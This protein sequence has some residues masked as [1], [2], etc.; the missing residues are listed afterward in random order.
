[1][2]PTGT[3]AAPVR[4][5]WIC[6]PLQI[7][8]RL[9]LRPPPLR[10]RTSTSAQSP[11][12]APSFLMSRSSHV[13]QRP[14]PPLAATVAPFPAVAAQPMT[15]LHLLQILLRRLGISQIWPCEILA[16]P[17]DAGSGD[18]RRCHHLLGGAAMADICAPLRASGETLGPGFWIGR[19]CLVCSRCPR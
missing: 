13:R 16:R 15:W 17:F 8:V 11:N 18:T 4:T 6:A 19:C 9:G 14:M 7:L 3:P 10:L 2:T 1:M 5:A 12:L